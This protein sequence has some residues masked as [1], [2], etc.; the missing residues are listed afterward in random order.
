MAKGWAGTTR[1]GMLGCVALGVA[2]W[3]GGSSN[4]WAVLRASDDAARTVLPVLTE[5]RSGQAAVQLP[6]GR[7]VLLGGRALLGDTA[8]AEILSGPPW[9]S[10]RWADLPS[11]FGTREVASLLP[12]GEMLLLG[13]DLPGRLLDVEDST[14]QDL[15]QVRVRTGQSATLL[16]DG[17]LLFLGGVDELGVPIRDADVF[18]PRESAGAGYAPQHGRVHAVDL[19]LVAGRSFHSAT[20]LGDGTVLVAGGRRGGIAD[21][22]LEI[23]DPARG[24]SRAL[25][26]GLLQPRSGHSATLLPDGRVLIAGGWSARQEPLDSVEIFD[27]ETTSIVA[28]PALA[29]PRAD[30]SATLVSGAGVMLLGGTGSRGIPAE[31]ESIVLRSDSPASTRVRAALPAPDATNVPLNTVV[32]LRFSAP[33]DGR[34][35][36]HERVVLTSAAGPVPATVT[37]AEAGAYLFVVPAALLSP[38]TVY[39]FEASG[40]RDVPGRSLPSFRMSFRTGSAPE[41]EEAG[42]E[43]QAIALGNEP[44]FVS[45]GEDVILTLPVLYRLQGWAGDDGQPSPLTY[46]W[47]FVSGP[48]GAWIAGGQLAQPLLRVTSPGTFVLR[49]TVSDGA[50]SVSDE[51]TVTVTT[52]GDFNADNKRDLLWQQNSGGNLVVWLM[53]GIT[54]IGSATAPNP[55]AVPDPNQK[56]VGL[57]DFNGD[58]KTD[59]LFQNQLTGILTAWLMDGLN[60]V[61]ETTPVPSGMPNGD[62]RWMVVGTPDLTG[63]GRPDLLLQ[64]QVTGELLVRQQRGVTTVAT[65][66]PFPDR[67]SDDFENWKIVSTD[68]FNDDGRHDILWQH[69][70]SSALVVWY[71]DGVTRIGSALPTPNAPASDAEN[72]KVVSTGDFN[73]DSHTDILWQHRL[74]GNM[75]VWFMFGVVRTSTGAPFPNQPANDFENWPVVGNYAWKRGSLPVPGISPAGGSFTSAVDVTLTGVYPGAIRY[76]LDGIDPTE[77]SSPYSQPVNVDKS[78]VLK[79]R[80]V[81][82]GWI[83]SGVASASYTI[84][85]ATPRFSLPSPGTYPYEQRVFVTC[86]TPGAVIHYTMTP[87]GTTPVDPTEA[88]PT[89][90]SGSFLTLNRSVIVR[91]KAWKPG[92]GASAVVSATYTVT[93]NPTALLVVGNVSAGADDAAYAHLAAMGFNILVKETCGA[94]CNNVVKADATSKRV[95]VI[96]SSVDSAHPGLLTLWDIT[97]PMI[98]YEP[99]IWDEFHMISAPATSVAQ[100]T[101]AIQ[102]PAHPVAGNRAGTVTV[103][104]PSAPSP[105]IYTGTVQGDAVVVG[106]TASAGTPALFAYDASTRMAGNQ[107]ARGRRVGLFDATRPL[108]ADGWKMFDAAVRWAADVRIAGAL[109]VGGPPTLPDN[110]PTVEDRALMSRLASMGFRVILRQGSVEPCISGQPCIENGMGVVVVSSTM[111]GSLEDRFRDSQVPVVVWQKEL[112]DNFKMT[113]FRGTT[114]GSTVEMTNAT[115]PL[116]GGLPLGPTPVATSNK[117]MAFSELTS[118]GVGVASLGTTPPGSARKFVFG[119]ERLAVMNGMDAPERRVG[120]FMQDNT[121]VS[122][123]TPAGWKLFQASVDWASAGDADNDGLST[124]EESKWGTDP[125]DP[126]SNDNGVLDGAEVGTSNPLSTDPDG[127]GLA[128][129]DELVKGTNP[130]NP[131]TD[132]DSPDGVACNDLTDVFPLDPSRCALPSDPTPALPPSILLFEPTNAELVIATCSPNPICPP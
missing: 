97:I 60:R 106:A 127:D 28:A 23:V 32:S 83:S 95:V 81:L 66:V 82:P 109:F 63:E 77:A 123:F 73:G 70:V 107:Y 72:W 122:G 131:D 67:S 111:D 3:G 47:S 4:P 96:S 110:V 121:I 12:G 19:R 26:S 11:V 25:R 74:T 18:D 102:S 68:D 1:V 41:A 9:R 51:V 45:A 54:R 64:H 22:S 10:E 52:R 61:S 49:L 30:H 80:A 130:F 100:R 24:E 119:Y 126:D 113:T 69:R 56:I 108:T 42:A 31:A 87:F 116:A 103:I 37:V 86:P 75:V 2:W 99:Q 46:S 71:M 62:P 88:D 118:A 89:V 128:N 35:V 38:E 43:A 104:D 44:P 112:W 125:F 59:F 13:S 101:I 34:S 93:G 79:A 117:E 17:R 21:G 15:T 120:L 76:S 57:A 55:F 29:A 114:V 16:L 84:A 78:G 129:P 115:H 7:V 65:H 53:N 14:I 48:G 105:L 33:I 27:P 36:S 5:P 132:G 58:G 90:A 92:A 20:L 124:K 94:G 8:G 98:V 85:V 50:V 40:L 6:D 39:A 91:A